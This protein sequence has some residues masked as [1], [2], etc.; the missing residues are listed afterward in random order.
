MTGDP[1]LLA[2][3]ETGILCNLRPD[4]VC[5]S[6]MLATVIAGLG[7]HITKSFRWF[8]G[9]ETRSGEMWYGC[10]YG[11]VVRVHALIGPNGNMPRAVR[12]GQIRR[13][14]DPDAVPA[15]TSGIAAPA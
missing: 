7:W 3:D 1:F 9:A 2:Q 10:I 12:Y 8:D 11:Y 13:I 4:A 15:A 5:K 6:G 14:T